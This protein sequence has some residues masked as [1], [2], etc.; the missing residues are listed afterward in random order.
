MVCGGGGCA[1]GT[2][3]ADRRH[4]LRSGRRRP[5]GRARGRT[6]PPRR[7][8]PRPADGG[9]AGRCGARL[10]HRWV[11]A[12]SPGPGRRP[13]RRPDRRGLGPRRLTTPVT[14]LLVLALAAPAAG[15]AVG[16]AEPAWA[17]LATRLS[18]IGAAGCWLVI[19]AAGPSVVRA[20]PIRADPLIAAA[21]CGA[22]R[23]VAG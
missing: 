13:R 18:A 4:R 20:G 3:R 14:V 5:G 2:R 22:A 1:G 6:A 19:V 17:R 10:V 12:S 15:G 23:I 7:W 11:G 9:V 16:L 8:S 21:A